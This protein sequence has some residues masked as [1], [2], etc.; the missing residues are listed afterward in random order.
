MGVVTPPV[1]VWDLPPILKLDVLEYGC[2]WI[3]D[4][5][6]TNADVEEGD[7]QLCQ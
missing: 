4:S 5:L 3:R 1:V 6:R 7:R 2:S